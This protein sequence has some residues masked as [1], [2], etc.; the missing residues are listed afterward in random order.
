MYSQLTILHTHA[1]TY[2][3]IHSLT[4]SLTHLFPHSLIHTLTHSTH[5]LTQLT[6]CHSLTLQKLT[7]ALTHSL[8]Q[9]THSLTNATHSLTHSLHLLTHQLNLLATG[10]Y[11]DLRLQCSWG[12]LSS[13]PPRTIAAIEQPGPCVALQI[14]SPSSI[15]LPCDYEVCGA[16]CTDHL[17]TCAEVQYGH[18][19][20]HFHP[21]IGQRCPFTTATQ[22]V[23]TKQYV[24]S[25]FACHWGVAKHP[26]GSI[27]A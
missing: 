13:L 14:D 22:C 27:L 1:L 20:L 23:S 10:R 19:T 21:S 12:V 16:A 25:H 6:S 11:M 15:K 26:S 4:H 8:T 24:R 2:S 18:V 7:H 9:S 17:T 3:L 5:P